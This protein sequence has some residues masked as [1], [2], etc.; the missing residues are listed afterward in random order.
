MLFDAGSQ[1]GFCRKMA[2]A[3]QLYEYSSEA[4]WIGKN[5]ED[6]D[7][8]HAPDSRA[9]KFLDLRNST[10]IKI[11]L[12]G[13]PITFLNILETW[14]GN[15]PASPATALRWTPVRY[16]SLIKRTAC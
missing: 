4:S 2:Y 6:S 11:V 8:S 14:H 1:A 10:A 3:G 16:L 5:E 9:K 12:T 15:M 7:F 13:K